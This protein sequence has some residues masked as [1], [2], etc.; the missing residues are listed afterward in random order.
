MSSPDAAQLR[1]EILRLVSR[2]YEVAHAKKPF[3]PGETKIPYAG[4]VYDDEELRLGV[5]SILQF[6]LTAGPFANQFE[7][8]MRDYFGSNAAYLV[9][10]GS[11]ANLLMIATLLSPQIKDGLRR[12][13]EV[14]TPAV[15]FPTTLTPLVQNGLIPVFV[16][17]QPGVYDIDVTQIEAAIGPKT[18]AIFV[19]HTVG[20]PCDL[21]ALT[22]I[23]TKHNLW[24]LED[25]CDALGS[26]WD[27]KLVGTFG[28]MSSISFYPA[29]HMTLGEG[30]MVVVNDTG[31]RKTCLSVRDWGRDCWCEPGVSDTCGKRFQWQLGSLP[32][33]YDHKY[34]YSNLGYNLKVSE[35]QAAVGV[36]QLGKLDAFVAARRA[37]FARLYEGLLDLQEFF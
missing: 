29:H 13:D 4:R 15:T 36:A 34:I 23:A 32:Y 33:G 26:T 37:N 24:L 30:G 28:A 11:S 14:I 10:S 21:D 1:D 17:C 19:P 5:E 25:G 7:K 8:L 20:I 18:R 12:G 31:L 2:Y 35:M 16:D 6:W 22:A 3:V 27:G 9:N